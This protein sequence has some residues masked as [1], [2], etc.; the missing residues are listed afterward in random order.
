MKI[1]S[2]FYLFL[3]GIILIP[4]LIL[5]I[6]TFI[7]AGNKTERLIVPSFDE[8]IGDENSDFMVNSETW[9]IVQKKLSRRSS[10]VEYAIFDE[11]FN[12]ILSSIAG[13][14]NHTKYPNNII[15]LMIKKDRRTFWYQVEFVSGEEEGLWMLTR[16]SKDN[17]KR[18]SQLRNPFFI[19]SM[20]LGVLFA[21][22]I[23]MII[24]ITHSIT[25]SVTFLEKYT[26]RI[27]GGELETE[28]LQKKA[29]RN[30]KKT[31]T[32]EIISLT[33]SI[34]KMKDELLEN[35]RRRMRFIMGLSHDLR[36]PIALIKGYSEALDD[37]MIDDPQ[38]RHNSL[39][40]ITEKADLLSDR[41]DELID[42]VKLN[43]NEWRQNLV[44]QKLKSF[45]QD[46]C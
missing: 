3:A 29:I 37:G 34:N 18:S 13:L 40:L 31:G 33:D 9:E 12:V 5:S 10:L 8:V 19:I 42:F 20:I 32:N 38:T 2:Q 22:C 43:T 26:R 46:F 24:L 45:L 30:S 23:I 28:D 35:E 25:N 1:K 15:L 11:D 16:L 14:E 6:L 27:S 17:F 41:I 44:P 4:I 21:F 36:T 7:I 39:Q